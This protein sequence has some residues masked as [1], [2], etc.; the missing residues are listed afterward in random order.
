[1]FNKLGWRKYS[2]FFLFDVNLVRIFGNRYLII[3]FLDFVCLDD[4]IEKDLVFGDVF[5]FVEDERM[6]S[7]EG[8]FG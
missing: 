8:F 3:K 7:L 1:M 5:V 6:L 4:K 2:I